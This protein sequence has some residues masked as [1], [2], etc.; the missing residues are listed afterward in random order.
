[1][2]KIVS[3]WP[4]YGAGVIVAVAEDGSVFSLPMLEGGRLVASEWIPVAPPVGTK[5]KDD[6]P[7]I[8][9]ENALIRYRTRARQE[10]KIMALDDREYE[11]LGR[12]IAGEGAAGS[13]F[14]EL[15]RYKF[16]GIEIV[17]HLGVEPGVVVVCDENFKLL[18]AF[19]WNSK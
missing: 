9:L 11:R 17:G 7:L 2:K 12:L 8:R 13:R 6:D 14:S 10:P 5:R 15:S 18:G 16:H 1:M 4:N 19:A 3:S